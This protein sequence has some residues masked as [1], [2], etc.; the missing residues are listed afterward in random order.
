[1]L[2]LSVVIAY[3]NSESELP[4]SYKSVAESLRESYLF[5]YSTDVSL[6]PG[7]KSQVVL[8]KKFDD[9]Q[10]VHAEKITALTDVALKEF[11]KE[12]SVPLM[13]QVGPENFAA[14]AEQG[15]PLAYLFWDPSD[16]SGLE[17]MIEQIK[18]VARQLKGRVNFVW[19]DAVK[20]AE[21]G[22][23]LN[24][25]Q[26][27]APAFVIQ[28]IANKGRKYVLSEMGKKLTADKIES[29]M[30]DYED[31]RVQ[32]SLKSAQPP[33]EQDEAVHVLVTN[34][35]DK[36]V[37]DDKKDVFIEFYAPWW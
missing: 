35:F 13:D 8:Y 33:A 25:P 26:D 10:A 23:S 1:M 20:F 7:G 4:A 19:I 22:K 5:G 31:G 14:Y 3:V 15:L 12:N 18:P 36:V 32:P 16:A 6:A 2:L 24:I 11:I 9:G 29:F 21:H 28:D 34:E 17:K 30:R 37:F 27:S